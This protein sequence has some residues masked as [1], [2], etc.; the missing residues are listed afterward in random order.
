MQNSNVPIQV[1][2]QKIKTASPALGSNERQLAVKLYRLLGEG[3]PVSPR[4]L[5]RA[6]NLPETRILEILGSWPGV[7]YDGE[8]SVIGFWGLALG[9]MPQR[10]EVDGRTL[11]TWC[12]WDSLF[13]P[14]LLGKTARVSSADPVTKEKISLV[15]GPDGIKAITPATTVVSFLTP[16]RPFD[17]DVIMSFCHFVH[18]FA[19]P[20]SA[21]KWTTEHPG[22]FQ[23]SVDDAWALGQVMNQ[24][25]AEDAVRSD[26][27]SQ[28]DPGR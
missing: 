20:E 14:D 25:K 26:T 23:L 11:Y 7:Y 18:F 27:G 10:F 3:K 1:L 19:S 9:E 6:I 15:V 24:R 5:A 21:K 17:Q 8:G 2:A 22:T 16:D 4:R 13:I 12:A 28:P